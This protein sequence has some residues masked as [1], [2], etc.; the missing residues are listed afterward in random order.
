MEGHAAENFEEVLSRKEHK[1]LSVKQYGL[2]LDKT[3]LFIGESTDRI[4]KCDCQ[5]DSWLKI[6]CPY[7]IC[8]KSLTDSDVFLDLIA[9]INIT[10]SVKSS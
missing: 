9:T 7:S 2:F 6:K 8:H 5:K 3:Y 1:T 10:H 4:L